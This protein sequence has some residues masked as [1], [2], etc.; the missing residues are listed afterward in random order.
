LFAIFDI[1]QGG[2][3]ASTGRNITA[4]LNMDIAYVNSCQ[5]G[6]AN[7]DG[8]VD[9]GDLTIVLANYN[10]TGMGWAGARAIS[11]TTGRWTSTT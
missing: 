5:R 7:G 11:P 1:C 9:I 6:D 10:Q 4:P 2:P 3:F 8:R